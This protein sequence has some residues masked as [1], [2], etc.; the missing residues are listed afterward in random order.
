LPG[1]DA[2]RITVPADERGDLRVTS[3]L[4]GRLNEDPV[5][6]SEKGTDS[7]VTW[8]A[9]ARSPVVGGRPWAPAP[10]VSFLPYPA[11]GHVDRVLKAKVTA[12][13]GPRVPGG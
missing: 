7:N 13:A 5:L 1:G 9:A 3:G 10:G 4:N 11:R 8:N 12:D 2:V 6:L